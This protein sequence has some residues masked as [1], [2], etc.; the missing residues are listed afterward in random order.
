MK[1]FTALML[2]VL[3]VVAL[4]PFS[5]SA[6]TW[7]KVDTA[8]E[9]AAMADGNYWLTADIDLSKVTWKTIAEF[10]GTLNGNGHTITLPKD[11]PVFDKL[12]GTVKNVNLKGTVTLNTA[13]S[14]DYCIYHDV[15]GYPVGALANVAWGA[16]IDNVTSNADVTIAKDTVKNADKNAGKNIDKA[17]GLSAGSLIGFATGAHTFVKET[18]G[19]GESAKEVLVAKVSKQTN[20]T[21]VTVAGKLTVKYM[22]G[23]GVAKHNRDNA[24]GVIGS[25]WG[26]VNLKNVLVT[27]EVNVDKSAGNCGGVI[28]HVN[29]R[30]IA[31]QADNTKDGDRT[32]AYDD[33][34]VLEKVVF[35]G[36]L[37]DTNRQGERAA[38]LVGYARGIHLLNCAVTGEWGGTQFI[39][40]SNSG[41]EPFSNTIEGCVSTNAGKTL[42]NSRMTHANGKVTLKDNIVIEGQKLNSASYEGANKNPKFEE[43][44]WKACHVGTK[45][46]ADAA[47]AIAEMAKVAG[48]KVE[49]G[50]LVLEMPAFT[51]EADPA[52]KPVT[53][54][55]TGD[56][57]VALVAVAV[58]SLAAVT[59]IAKKKVTE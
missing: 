6:A 59:V 15:N 12:S 47:A 30:Y 1:K 10:K 9:F 54:A 33:A 53:P 13:D 21:N 42:A 38:A 45:T 58:V 57:T 28:G 4:V 40:Y 26:D 25:S 17:A 7:T 50:K 29:Q 14:S 27:A 19:E 48:Y 39:G 32:E 23:E 52:D 3:M 34:V 37:V 36:K 2:V 11:A 16:T 55:P 5:A 44:A 51:P 24:G 18:Q 41:N 20:I 46:V 35:A 43:D 22:A 8:A 49:G 31:P 56:M